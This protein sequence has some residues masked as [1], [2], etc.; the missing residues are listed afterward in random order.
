VLSVICICGFTGGKQVVVVAVLLLLLQLQ[1]QMQM[2]MGREA[3]YTEVTSQ[4]KKNVTP[5]P[6]AQWATYRHQRQMPWLRGQVW[7]RMDKTGH[8]LALKLHLHAFCC[9]CEQRRK[10]KCPAYVGGSCEENKNDPGPRA[11]LSK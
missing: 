1:L 9:T 2:Q 10:Q 3:T 4:C 11:A 5:R 6:L 7:F 8:L